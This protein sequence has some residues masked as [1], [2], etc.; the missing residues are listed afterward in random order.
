MGSAWPLRLALIALV[1]PWCCTLSQE[2]S[3]SSEA[4]VCPNCDIPRSLARSKTKLALEYL[5]AKAKM[6]LLSRWGLDGYCP[7]A[8]LPKAFTKQYPSVVRASPVKARAKPS[9]IAARP[10]SQ[11]HRTRPARAITATPATL[12]LRSRNPLA[13]T[14]LSPCD[15]I[16]HGHHRLLP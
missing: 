7:A 12:R 1:V 11:H 15:T 16:S 8:C 10:C 14:P 13:S 3:G 2:Q 9:A 5:H 6:Y 4:Q